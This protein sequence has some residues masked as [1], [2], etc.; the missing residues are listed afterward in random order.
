V[1]RVTCKAS[2]NLFSCIAGIACVPRLTYLIRSTCITRRGSQDAERSGVRDGV[3][4]AD[5]EHPPSAVPHTNGTQVT[6]LDFAPNEGRTHAQYLGKF[7]SRERPRVGSCETGEANVA[8]VRS[9]HRRAFLVSF[10]E[11]SS[12]M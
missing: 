7:G 6:G 12:C 4:E 2:I 8:L 3:G 10:E 5:A 11:P 1:G 9:R